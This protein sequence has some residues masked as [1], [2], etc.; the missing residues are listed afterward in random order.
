MGNPTDALRRAAETFAADGSVLLVEPMAGEKDGDN[1]NPV[2]RMYSGASVLVCSPHAIAESGVA[3]GTIG[4]E[5]EL[6]SVVA[7][8]G[9]GQASSASPLRL[10]STASSTRHR[11]ATPTSSRKEQSAP[12]LP[13]C[14]RT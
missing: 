9:L 10:R 12:T 4:T 13:T 2:G 14:R 3:L 8:A 1:L 6:R 7:A 5:A 11:N